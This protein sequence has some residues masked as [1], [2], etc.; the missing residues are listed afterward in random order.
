[1]LVV[2]NSRAKLSRSVK[3]R[4]AL[5]L[6][7]HCSVYASIFFSLKA[8]GLKTASW[9]DMRRDR[10]RS[11]FA[12]SA[13]LLMSSVFS[14]LSAYLCCTRRLSSRRSKPAFHVLMSCDLG[15]PTVDEAAERC[16]G[17]TEGVRVGVAL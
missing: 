14:L 13:S 4:V 6:C 15:S 3:N 16:D 11:S 5:R 9:P 2:A 17:A 1:M 8:F 12:P 7:V 10:A